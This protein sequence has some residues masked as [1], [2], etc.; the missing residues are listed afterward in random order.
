MAKAFK[1]GKTMADFGDGGASGVPSGGVA[2]H[3]GS[4]R[5]IARPNS[6]PDGPGGPTSPGGFG[7]APTIASFGTPKRATGSGDKSGA[8]GTG[9]GTVQT[10]GAGTF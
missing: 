4:P 9:G 5:I 10:D 7:G 3:K 6:V 8:P 1:G 2:G